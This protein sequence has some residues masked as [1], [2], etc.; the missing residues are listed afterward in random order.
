MRVIPII[1]QQM[2]KAMPLWTNHKAAIYS[3][4]PI[5]EQ[6]HLKLTLHSLNLS[7]SLSMPETGD[8]PD[9][10]RCMKTTVVWDVPCSPVEVHRRFKCMLHLKRQ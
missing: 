4:G 6:L 10:H 2:S 1:S 7:P 5:V 8:I 9:S 3:A